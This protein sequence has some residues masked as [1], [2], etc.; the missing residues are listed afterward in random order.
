MK[1]DNDF[2]IEKLSSLIKGVFVTL[3]NSY[4]TDDN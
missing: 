4:K 1:K 3:L 2:R